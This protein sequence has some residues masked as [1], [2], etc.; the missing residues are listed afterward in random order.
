MSTVKNSENTKAADNKTLFGPLGKYAIIGVIMGSV[1]VTT[2]IMM[3]KQPNAEEHIAAI[4]KE[5][6]VMNAGSAS[7]TNSINTELATEVV[8][9]TLSESNAA[10]SSVNPTEIEDSTIRQ[11]ETAVSDTMNRG[12]TMESAVAQVADTIVSNDEI[13]SVNLNQVNEPASTSRQPKTMISAETVVMN[14]DHAPVPHQA[15]VNDSVQALQPTLAVDTFD[16]EWEQYLANRKVEEKQHLSEFFNRIRSRESEALEQYKQDQDEY[17]D[18]LREQ[19]SRQEQTIEKLILRN[20][21]HYDMREASMQHRQQRRE[22]ML[23]RI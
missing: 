17:I 22:S 10:V 3:D 9:N 6:A 21:V 15:I 16:Q 4:E 2:A 12:S 14:I 19:I 8:N 11:S 5:V 23:N 20:Q 1:I 7:V 13:S 18:F